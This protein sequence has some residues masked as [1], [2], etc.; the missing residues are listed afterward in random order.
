MHFFQISK[1]SALLFAAFFTFSLSSCEKDG[2][3]PE[4]EENITEEEA[5]DII[6]AALIANTEGV[7]AEVEDAAYI[8]DEYSENFKDSPEDRDPNSNPCEETFDSTIVRSINNAN[9]TAE[10]SL[11][12]IWSFTCNAASLPVSMD[13][14]S[15]SNG[16]FET[17]RLISNNASNSQWVVE[18]LLTGTSYI[19]NGNYARTGTSESKI[20][21][22]NTYGTT[23]L[24]E[25]DD[26]HIDKSSRRITSGIAN[27]SL[28]ASSPDGNET[29]IEADIV[30]NGGGSATIIINGN[31]YTIS[32]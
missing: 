9:L 25:V 17:Q 6:E 8:A 18:N 29:T 19:I 30:F 1:L 28:T 5:V 10:Y 7:S 32:L 2:N 21:N 23:I 3:N 14:A 4:G 26:L 12:W 11:N 13:F 27:V 20:H 15:T 22:Q 16:S 24:I 31:S